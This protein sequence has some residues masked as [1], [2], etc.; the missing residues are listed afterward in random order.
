MALGSNEMASAE[1]PLDILRAT[2]HDVQQLLTSQTATSWDVVQLYLKQ[3]EAHNHDGLHLNAV[4]SL[5]PIEQLHARAVELDQ[6]RS[7]GHVR[8]PLHGIPILVKDN[9]MTEASLGMDTTC[10]SYALKGAKVKANAD[11][12]DFILKAG[13]IILG[14]ANLSVRTPS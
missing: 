2:A 14:K 1:V 11:V 7:Q 8:G 4:I 12:I 13:M 5:A 3:I 10:G 9:I 6:E